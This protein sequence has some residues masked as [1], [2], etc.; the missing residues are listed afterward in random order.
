MAMMAI[1]T[2]NSISVNPWSKGR[3]VGVLGLFM[4]WRYCLHAPGASRQANR[5]PRQRVYDKKVT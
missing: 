1:T 5:Q 2:S 4:V 3:G